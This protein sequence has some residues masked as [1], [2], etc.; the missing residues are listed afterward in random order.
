MNVGWIF[1]ESYCIQ[2]E[3]RTATRSNGRAGGTYSTPVWY[4]TD[5]FTQMTVF[6]C[7]I[8]CTGVPSNGALVKALES[9]ELYIQIWNGIA[10]QHM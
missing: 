10:C 5:K 8:T 7:W 4:G 2:E 9:V 6:G 3:R 1:Y